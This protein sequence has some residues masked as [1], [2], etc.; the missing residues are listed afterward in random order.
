MPF[1]SM[2]FGFFGRLNLLLLHKL[3]QLS[4]LL[5]SG[6]AFS[7][8]F[9]VVPAFFL[10]PALPS[11]SL[12][13]FTLLGT[14]LVACSSFVY[15]QII[16]RHRDAL[17]TRTQERSLVLTGSKAA[18][19]RKISLTFAHIIGSSFL[20]L[21]LYILFVG[22][23]P[24]AALAALGSFVYYVFIYTVILKPRTHWNTVLGGICG[25]IGPL[26]GELAVNHTIS[27][28]GLMMFALLFVWQP[29]HFWCLAL[30]YKEDY[31]RAHIPVLPVSKGVRVTLQQILFYQCLLCF[32]ILLTS[33]PPLELFGP[34]FLWPS[35]C[36]GLVVLYSMWSLKKNYLRINTKGKNVSDAK[37][38]SFKPMRV[39]ALSIVHMLLWHIALSL[40]LYL[41]FW[42]VAV[43]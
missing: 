42:G 38:P 28:Y 27:E 23:H 43:F 41:R 19:E 9:T 3:Q 35:L 22:S 25:S 17:M 14:W 37:K 13:I 1:T 20:G 32:L 33:L 40:D 31:S 12:V 11:Y 8:L 24:F 16:E 5:K 15:N 10:G 21:G 2:P 4:S 26:I 6:L 34:V 36:I 29:P 30:Y 39:F 18:T 7:I